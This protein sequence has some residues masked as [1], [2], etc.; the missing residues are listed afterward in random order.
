MIFGSWHD[1]CAVRLCGGPGD[2]RGEQ[3]AL[4][5]PRADRGSA[6]RL[7]PRRPPERA[8]LNHRDQHDTAT[9]ANAIARRGGRVAHPRRFDASW[10]AGNLRW[11]GVRLTRVLAQP[12]QRRLD[13]F[14]MLDAF[15]SDRRRLYRRLSPITRTRF[16]TVTYMIAG[17]MRHRD[18]AAMRD[19]CKTAVCVDEMPQAASFIG[20]ARAGV[21]SD[22]GLS[23]VAESAGATRCG[24]LV[25]RHPERKHSRVTTPE[26]GARAGHRGC[27]A[28]G[29][30]AHAT[31]RTQTRFTSIFTSAQATASLSRSRPRTMHSCYVYAATA[32]RHTRVPASACDSRQHG[33]C[34]RVILRAERRRRRS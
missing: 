29:W 7:N 11:A 17:R 22:G 33:R 26:G 19:F 24:P 30:Q 14:L 13:P 8:A 31:R 16:E 4:A 25:S 28:M 5:R 9:L 32:D 23:A 15:G 18:S 21:G 3:Q 10:P 27:E 2:G 34:R 1:G 12:L 6:V 20:T